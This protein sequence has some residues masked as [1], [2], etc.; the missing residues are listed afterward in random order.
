MKK[1]KKKLK[2]KC[3][4][5]RKRLNIYKNRKHRK[6]I[7]KGKYKISKSY[8]PVDFV[9]VIL[10]IEKNKPGVIISISVGIFRTPEI[11]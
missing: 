9:V 4:T 11:N 6:R 5:K 3:K 10:N 8:L 1:Y 2:M 7:E